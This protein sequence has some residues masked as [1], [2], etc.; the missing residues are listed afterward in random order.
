M[1]MQLI[2]IEELMELVR[3]NEVSKSIFEVHILCFCHFVWIIIILFLFLFFF[4][5]IEKNWSSIWTHVDVDVRI[6]LH[7]CMYTY[8]YTSTFN[9]KKL[10]LHEAFLQSHYH[11]AAGWQF[12]VFRKFFCYILWHVTNC[13]KIGHT[14]HKICHKFYSGHKIVTKFAHVHTNACIHEARLCG[15]SS[16]QAISMLLQNHSLHVSQSFLNRFRF[17]FEFLKETSSMYCDI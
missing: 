5:L 10:H 6:L 11:D 14:R 7:A 12:V 8:T 3:F 15:C 9:S 16:S 2:N 13:H 1:S 4:F 17:S